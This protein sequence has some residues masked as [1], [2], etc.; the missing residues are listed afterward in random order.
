M[1]NIIHIGLLKKKKKRANSVQRLGFGNS[2]RNAEENSPSNAQGC[3][4]ESSY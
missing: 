4:D 1:F 2:H 3:P